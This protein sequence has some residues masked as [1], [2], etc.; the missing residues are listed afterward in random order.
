MPNPDY[1]NYTL[2]A[3]AYT[4]RSRDFR[5]SGTDLLFA[6]VSYGIKTNTTVSGHIS[7]L[8]SLIGSV[9]QKI[10][11]GENLD[12]GFALSAGRALYAPTDSLVN[13]AG[14]QSMV[15]LGDF[16]N[17]LT[18]GVGI[19]YTHSNFELLEDKR[20]VFFN[21]VYAA[22]QRQLWSKIYLMA[23]GMYFWDY[24]T[25]VGS[26]VLKFIIKRD[27]SL[28]VGVMPL[29]RDGRIAPNRSV[30][31]AG[32]IPVISYRWLLSRN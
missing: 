13:I 24:N 20:D 21:H 23:E 7:L 15:T 19:Y 16:Q 4:L 12:L 10:P 30:T 27:Y 6:K 22:V 9:K 32:V 2:T 1:T 31:E 14:G 25:F 17:N 18:A 3:S 28:C 26:V 5:F 11:L 29:A 8:G